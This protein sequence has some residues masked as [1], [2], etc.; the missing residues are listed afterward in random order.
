MKRG[1]NLLR[2]IQTALMAAIIFVVTYIVRIPMPIASGGYLN[3]GDAPLY[4]AAYLLGGPA[5]AIAGA[6][7]SAMS[8]LAAGYVI[9]ALPTAIIK[10]TMGFVCGVI[11]N[12]KRV[13]EKCVKGTYNLTHQT[14]GDGGLKRFIL[15]S[16]L[17][18]AI[19]VGGYAIFEAIFFNLNQA[20][21]TVPFN[22]VQWAGGVAAALALFPAVRAADK[23]M[24]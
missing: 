16:I 5:G 18:G 13:K 14:K 9:Y 12:R 20:M 11:M 2:V 24:K 10:G 21:A 8:D 4:I 19:M 7:G 15:A 1:S 6:L 17:G 23:A 3:I 22:C